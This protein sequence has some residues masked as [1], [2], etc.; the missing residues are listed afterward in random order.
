MIL[1]V[2]FK[3]EI[4]WFFNNEEGPLG[5]SGEENEEQGNLPGVNR[6]ASRGQEVPKGNADY[7]VS[8]LW[9]REDS[10]FH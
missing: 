9:K 10:W 1:K 6:C 5:S 7:F 2:L 4:M 8:S 3:F